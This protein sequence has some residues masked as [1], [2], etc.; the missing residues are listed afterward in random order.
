MIVEDG[1]SRVEEQEGFSIDHI[2]NESSMQQTFRKL[3]LIQDHRITPEYKEWI[4]QYLNKITSDLK[5]I[6][7]QFENYEKAKRKTENNLDLSD[8][9]I[10][11][12]QEKPY[13]ELIEYQIKCRL[14]ECV[15]K[16]C[17][18]KGVFSTAEYIK[19]MEHFEIISNDILTQNLYKYKMSNIVQKV[20]AL[21]KVS[22]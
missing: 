18:S 17:K 5:Q 8:S 2:W 1:H 10:S 9:K 15:M 3:E 6:K 4:L 16:L 19:R 7:T 12:G 13:Q 22:P 14:L 11:F 21:K 20:R